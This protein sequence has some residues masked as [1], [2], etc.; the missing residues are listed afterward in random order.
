MKAVA[1]GLIAQFGSTGSIVIPDSEPDPITGIGGADS[2]FP[3]L[4]F[5][6]YSTGREL[7]GSRINEELADR[8]DNSDATVYV[9]FDQRIYADW[10][11][12]DDMQVLWNIISVETIETQGSDVMYE[13]HIRK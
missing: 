8:V 10:G 11:F 13:V 5:R 6:E 1:S 3:V 9:V 4:Y 7:T 12:E 2:K